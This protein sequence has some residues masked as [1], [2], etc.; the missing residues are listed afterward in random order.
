MEDSINS[1]TNLFPRY[2]EIPR[3]ISDTMWRFIQV[4][5]V[6]IALALTY[7]LFFYPDTGL[8]ILWKIAV[9]LLPLVFVV[10]PGL[11]R[12]S[13]PLAFINQIPRIFGFTKGLNTPAIF[14][15]YG[16]MIAFSILFILVTSRKI[17]FNSSGEATAI[18]IL[19]IVVLTFIGGL[20]IKGKGGFCSSIC[21]VL[22]VE[23]IY[24][25]SPF[26]V[27]PNMHCRPCVGC[28]VYCYDYNPSAAYLADQ[29]YENKFHSFLRKLFASFFPGYVLSYFIVA[30]PPDNPVFLM[31][32]KMLMFSAC[33]SIIFFLL[34]LIIKPSAN[35]LPPLFGITA[36]SIYYWFTFPILSESLFVLSGIKLSAEIIYV[37]RFLIILF[38]LYWLIRT[39]AKEKKFISEIL[40][41]GV[42][43]FTLFSSDKVGKIE[44]KV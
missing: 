37:L 21:P 19:I 17:I 11:W 29:Y 1:S 22:P 43:V 42:P 36:F 6:I 25:Q 44:V 33:S 39:Y 34:E 10:V 24:G 38:S 26:I 16:Y 3:K 4:A 9:P 20:F 35:K 30:G 12:N 31:I 5:G 15:K 40:A 13:C 14:V 18:L 2:M 28:T 23:R 7:V 32:A 8:F 27:L 41:P